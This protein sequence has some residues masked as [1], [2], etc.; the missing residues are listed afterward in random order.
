MNIPKPDTE[1]KPEEIRSLLSSN[2]F[3]LVIMGSIWNLTY[4]KGVYNY[5]L[6]SAGNTPCV[7]I[8]EDRDSVVDRWTSLGM[9]D[10]NLLA[11]FHANS[12]EIESSISIPFYYLEE[13]CYFGKKTID[14]FFAG[15]PNINRYFY[16]DK[17]TKAGYKNIHRS[18]VTNNKSEYLKHLRQS[19][20]GFGI[21]RF[22]I[23]QSS[24][25]YR[26]IE[27]T[28]QGSCLF[29]KI[30]D[31]QFKQIHEFEDNISAIYYNNPD[32]LLEKL[33]I[34]LKDE[35]KLYQIA[36]NGY[37]HVMNYHLEHQGA[38]YVLDNIEAR[39]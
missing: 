39:L 23:P 37:D 20:T 5:I 28:S 26:H 16:M 33:N 13:D 17:L 12:K 1:Y 4:M 25:R 8:S 38:Q 29:M 22:D 15:T 24:N 32:D 14:T 7:I 3:D 34:V 11:Y 18:F 19:K 31:P 10:M 27:V 36:K 30:P 6:S 21:Y 35:E 2:R 9:V